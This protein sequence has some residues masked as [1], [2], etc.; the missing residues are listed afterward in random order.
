VKFI[1]RRNKPPEISV[2]DHAE[3]MGSNKLKEALKYG[4]LTSMGEDTEAAT[5]AEKGIGL[6][7]AMMAL[8]ENWLITIKDGLINERNK[9]PDFTTG[10]GKENEKVTEEERKEYGIFTNGTI[11]IGKLPDYFRLRKTETIVDRLQRHF[12]M[13]KLIHHGDFKIYVID[14]W[15][16]KKTLLKYQS[17]SKE[18]EVLRESFKIKYAGKGYNIHLLINKST[19]TLTPGK[20]YGDSG[21]LFYYGEYSVLDFTFYRYDKDLAFTKFF[22]EAKMEIGELLRDIGEA[23]LVDAKRRG[24]DSEH[25]FNKLLCREINKRLASLQEKEEASKY[26]FDENAL[27]DA[28]KE[29]NK[30]YSE[31]KGRG[32]PPLP[33]IEPET[34]AFHRPHCSLKEY[35]PKTVFLIINSDIISDGLELSIESTNPDII[36]KRKYIKIDKAPDSDFIIKQISLYSEKAEITGEIIAKSILPPNLDSEKMGVE[37]LANPMFSPANGIAFVPD[38]TTIVDGGKKKVDLCINKT[39]ISSRCDIAL[40]SSGPIRCPGKWTLPSTW[41][42]EKYIIKNIAKIEIPIETKGKENIGEKATV[43]ASYKDRSSSLDVTIVLE[44]S[45]SGL[46]RGI[47]PSPK[48]TKKISDFV[49]TEGILEY[50]YKHPLIKKYMKKDFMNRSEFLVFVADVLTREAIKAVVNSGIEENSSRFPI[51]DMDNPE[52]EIDEHVRR[53]YFEQGLT[54]HNLFMKL[55]R[56]IKLGGE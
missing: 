9:H 28:L 24:L 47:R 52:L 50:Y 14:S 1:S 4:T 23:P 56:D 18:K 30:L 22:G 11:V 8:D 55:L 5:S 43:H 15:T 32:P 3:G 38:K 34:F 20:P 45:I 21:I 36:V 33:P 48:N 53:E 44:P 17:P 10:I 49:K 31:I 37:V 27:K 6:K 39:L 46:F 29:L 26:T 25:R 19:E 51:F 54:M 13:R 41:G 40:S 2:L 7:D 42:L 35:E 12:L 16:K